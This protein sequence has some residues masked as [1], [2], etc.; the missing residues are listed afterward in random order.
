MVKALRERTLLRVVGSL[1]TL[2]ASYQMLE[3]TGALEPRQCNVR[4][5]SMR[6]IHD[7]A[8]KG[9]VRVRNDALRKRRSLV[10]QSSTCSETANAS[11]TSMPR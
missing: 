3:L 2:L 1:I 6:D 5:T 10:C 11:S 8:E 4:F 9:R 7:K